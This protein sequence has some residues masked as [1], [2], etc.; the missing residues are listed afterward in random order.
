[1][2][3]R[4]LAACA[5][6]AATAVA[7]AGCSS[8]PAAP[9]RAVRPVPVPFSA[10]PVPVTPD[11]G[12][13][14]RTALMRRLA[15]YGDARQSLVATE[16]VAWDGRK[17]RFD[18][19]FTWGSRPAMDVRA[20]TA[21]LAMQELSASDTT[22][23]LLVD[24]AFYY[25]VGPRPSGALRGRHWMKVPVPRLSEEGLQ[26]NP[27]DGLWMAADAA[28]V[29]D[30]GSQNVDGTVATHYQGTVDRAALAA[31]RRLVLAGSAPPAVLPAGAESAQ[32]DVWVDA[33]GR[34]VGWVVT[35]G[36]GRSISVDVT[37][38]GG[39]RSIA[40]PPVADTAD[41]AAVGGRPAAA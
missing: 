17:V 13:A 1:M 41:A 28:G 4:V 16:N 18:G 35:C 10:S 40:A 5:A 24:G 22:E 29:I 7:L 37:A 15:A 39:P 33:R 30:L 23:V 9:R 20:P 32:L 31:D 34:P 8:G 12:R 21:Q 38:L 2:R 27:L 14:A 6:V 36:P 26:A 25:G 19:L 3:T 11:P